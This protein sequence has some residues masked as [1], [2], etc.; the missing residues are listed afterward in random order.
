MDGR[1]KGSV[2]DKSLFLYRF[3]TAT[4]P[5]LLFLYR[6]S[7]ASPISLPFLSRTF[8][9]KKIKIKIVLKVRVKLRVRTTS[10][11]Y[12]N[13]TASPFSLPQLYR[14]SRFSPVFLPFFYRFFTVS[15]PFLTLAPVLVRIKPDFYVRMATPPQVYR[16]FLPFDLP[17]CM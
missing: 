3:F 8:S 1:E 5:H 12:C 13:S 15:L 10:R 4:L 11:F 9:G 6:N 16:P 14:I 17:A 2:T 7:T